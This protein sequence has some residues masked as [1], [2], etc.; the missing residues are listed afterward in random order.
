[1][2]A[3]NNNSVDSFFWVIGAVW[4]TEI[5]MLSTVRFFVGCYNADFS[6]ACFRKNSGVIVELMM[7]TPMIIVMVSALIGLFSAGSGKMCRIF[8]GIS[9]VGLFLWAVALV[10]YISSTSG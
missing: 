7:I 10:Y 8:Y 9:G 2:N 5:S 4:Y 3:G 6:G 1:M